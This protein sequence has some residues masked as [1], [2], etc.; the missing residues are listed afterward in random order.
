M[1]TIIKNTEVEES[2]KRVCKDCGY[3]YSHSYSSICPDC[4]ARK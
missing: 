3:R 1:A 2:K 4:I